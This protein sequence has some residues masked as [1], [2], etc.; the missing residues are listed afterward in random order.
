MKGKEA[1]ETSQKF[2]TIVL[3]QTFE[4]S[5]HLL[6]SKAGKCRYR[7]IS[8]L[9]SQIKRKQDPDFYRVQAMRT[10]FLLISLVL[11]H[12]SCQRTA[13][14]PPAVTPSLSSQIT[15][16]QELAT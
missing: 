4:Q 10:N 7:E 6:H 2:D 3:Q 16:L 15:K 11:F 14:F 9:T 1:A 5:G 13:S 12:H 8:A